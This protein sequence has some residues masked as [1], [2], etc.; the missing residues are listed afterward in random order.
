[1]IDMIGSVPVFV[2]DQTRALE[3][4]K[5][6]LGFDVSM[7]MPISQGIRW[8]TV[9]PRKGSTEFI[10][11]PPELAGAEADSMRA[12]VGSW[13]GITILSDDCRAD[14]SRL[15][16]RGVQFKAAPTQPF[17]GG[18]IAEFSDLDGNKFQLV[19]RPAYMR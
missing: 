13:T 9:T 18:W 19:E 2:N 8:L 4:Y 6:R 11:F 12:R 17:W 5:D 7:D 16:E 1:M 15:V 14:Y 10:L 3:F